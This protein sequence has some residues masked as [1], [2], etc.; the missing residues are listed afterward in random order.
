MVCMCV[1]WYVYVCV[2]VCVSVC[3]PACVLVCK[4]G[5]VCV[6]PWVSSVAMLLSIGQSVSMA[7]VRRPQTR[8][9]MMAHLYV[10]LHS[11]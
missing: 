2:L 7:N 8:L 11:F 6:C 5:C 4:C 10:Q 9:P 1:C 3:L